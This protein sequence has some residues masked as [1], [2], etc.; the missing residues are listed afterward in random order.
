MTAIDVDDVLNVDRL[1]TME[2]AADI[3]T[4]NVKKDLFSIRNKILGKFRTCF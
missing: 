2:G 3:K 4:E 1:V